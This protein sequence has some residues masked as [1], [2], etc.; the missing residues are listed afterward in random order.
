[1]SEENQCEQS[2]KY[3]KEQVF[4]EKKSA[5]H[6]PASPKDRNRSFESERI[7]GREKSF[8]DQERD[9]GGVS[10]GCLTKLRTVFATY[11]QSIESI[12]K[13]QIC[14]IYKAT[15]YLFL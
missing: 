12:N 5:R 15:E 4:I 1:M 13:W 6:I 11:L 10:N 14:H 3:K 8:Q 7:L 9:M 2:D